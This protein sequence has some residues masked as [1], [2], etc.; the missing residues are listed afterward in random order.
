[1]FW[2][3]EY[4]EMNKKYQCTSCL[5][6]SD[7]TDNYVIWGSPRGLWGHC[8]DT[9]CSVPSTFFSQ[10]NNNKQRP[11]YILKWMKDQQRQ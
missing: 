11:E 1:M 6:H 8:C 9:V 7:K 4:D 3:D 2:N 5:Q 10:F